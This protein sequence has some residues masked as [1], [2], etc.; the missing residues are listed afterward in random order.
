MMWELSPGED[1]RTYP[2]VTVDKRSIGITRCPFHTSRYQLFT[3]APAQTIP[4]QLIPVFQ[5]NQLIPFLLINS[6][7]RPILQDHM[8]RLQSIPPNPRQKD[9]PNPPINNP[10]K[11][12]RNAHNG[13]KPIRQTR[14]PLAPRRS[15]KRR[16]NLER[17]ASHE[18]HSNRPPHPERAGHIRL[19][20][21]QVEHS[22]HDEEVDDTAGIPL[23]IEDEVVCVAEGDGHDHD[24]GWDEV[25]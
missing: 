20:P 2:K 13:I 3:T 24:Q 23:E 15:N 19:S 7:S 4:R 9:L 6:H 25:Q 5:Y 12:H 8:L 18:K 1:V 16:H 10:R 14:I 21:P 17:L 22:G 11:Q